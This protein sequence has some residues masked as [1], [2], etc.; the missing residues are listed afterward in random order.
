MVIQGREITNED[1][2]LVNRLSWANPLWNRTRLSQEICFLW[3]WRAANSQIKD[4]AC[5]T[6][7]G[8]LA[9]ISLYLLLQHFL[10]ELVGKPLSYFFHIR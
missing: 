8:K 4:M 5:R 1:I 10:A 9:W 7:L 6:F 2:E 3:N